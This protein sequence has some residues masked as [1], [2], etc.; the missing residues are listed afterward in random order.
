MRAKKAS[1]T[2]LGLERK[3]A[4]AMGGSMVDDFNAA[5]ATQAMQSLWLAHSTKEDVA[6]HK[7]TVIA[8]MIGIAPRNEI[9]GMLAAQ[10]VATHH[11]AME[12]FRRAMLPEQT[13]EGRQMALTCGNK[14]VRSYATL[15]EALD[16]HRGKG[17]PQVV[18]VE[19]VTVEAGGQAIV[20][21]VTQGGG[22]GTE[23]KDQ[24]YAQQL[25][26][27]PEPAV[28]CPDPERRPLPV[29]EGEG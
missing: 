4:R 22:G 25:A 14:L 15:V 3:I 10:M 23:S 5:V 19:R 20:G 9:E 28:R 13:F 21:A 7:T 12:C 24:P 6:R 8:T 16:R 1:S 11:A 26:H 29:A 17:Q 27:A 2:D 18:R